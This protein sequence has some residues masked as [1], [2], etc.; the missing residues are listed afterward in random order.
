MKQV[1]NE[2]IQQN[3]S[4]LETADKSAKNRIDVSLFYQ[5]NSRMAVF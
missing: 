1:K 4:F 3:T 2:K 5:K